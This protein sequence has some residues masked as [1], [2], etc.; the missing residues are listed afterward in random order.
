MH[1]ANQGVVTVL[2]LNTALDELLSSLLDEAILFVFR[3]REIQ[4]SLNGLSFRL[5]VQGSLGA[6]DL[7][8]VQ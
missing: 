1:L 2:D 6:L 7:G 8:S 3:D 5:G 4:G